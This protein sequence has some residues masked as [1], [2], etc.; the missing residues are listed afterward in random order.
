[1]TAGI[2]TLLFTDIVGSTERL[3]RLGDDAYDRL[4]RT[5]FRLLRD[6]V[7]ARGGNEVKNLGDGLFVTFPSVVNAVTAAIEMQQAVARESPTEDEPFEIR[8]GLSIGEPIVDESDY[9]GKPVVVAQRL[10]AAAEPGQILASTLVRDLAATRQ[11]VEVREMGPQQLK[12]IAEPV[13]AVE[14]IWAPAA[15]PAL[16]PGL[17]PFDGELFVGREEELGMLLRTWNEAQAGERRAVLIGGEPGIGKSSLAASAARAAADHGAIVLYGRCDEDLGVPYQPFVEALTQYARA[18]SP[19]QL[20]RQAG[21]NIGELVRLL[22]DLAGWYDDLP[23]PVRGEPETERYQLFR[24]VADLF[25]GIA[26]DRPV[27]LV[28]DDIHWAAKP[29]LLLLWHLLRNSAAVPLM[30]IATYRHTEVDRDHILNE[31]LADLHRE[32]GVERTVLGGLDRA[33]VGAFVAAVRGPAAAEERATLAEAI[34]A[35]TDGNP[36]FVR[37][38][39]AHLAENNLGALPGRGAPE[40]VLPD[41]VR[42]VVARR[43]ARLSTAANQVL[44]VGS[45][46]GPVFSIEL[47]EHLSGTIDDTG[48]VLEA[49]EE[50]VGAGLLLEDHAFVGR[51]VFAHAL[52]RET[53]YDQLGAVRRA[54]LHRRVGEV[55][56]TLPD[57]EH[58]LDELAYH[59]ARAVP[60]GQAEKA[61]GYGVRAGRRALEGLAYE[62]GVEHLERALAALEAGASVDMRR[63]ADLLLL[64]ADARWLSGDRPGAVEAV[65]RAAEDA[66]ATGSAQALAQAFCIRAEWGAL[67][68]TP[69]PSTV[70]LGEE[71]LEAL[72]D[73]TS[74]LK[75]R[76][77]AGLADY[78]ALTTGS[79]ALARDL[80]S[81]ALELARAGDDVDTLDYVLLIRAATFLGTNQV[82][83]QLELLDEALKL[84]QATGNMRRRHLGLA[85]R[86]TALLQAGEMARFKSD[87]Q[88][89]ACLGEERR[90]WT[91][92]A[93]ASV[94]AVAGA[95]AEGRFADV[96]DL[97]AR[98]LANTERDPNF[99]NT[100]AVQML[101]LRWEQGRLDELIP[102]LIGMAAQN[103]DLVAF[104]TAL[105]FA[106][107]EVGALG[108]AR[109]LLDSLAGDGFAA[110]PQDLTWP[111]SLALLASAAA[112]LDT[113]HH[114][115]K[116]FEF[117][118]PLSG[119]LVIVGAGAL[120]LGSVDRYLGMLAACGKDFDVA[121]GHYRSALE[122]EFR[123]GALPYVARTRYWY[124]RM[125]V[126]RGGS[127]DREE[128]VE[129]L[130]ACLRTAKELGMAT[131]QQQALAALPA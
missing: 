102:M 60:D 124:A 84:Q 129:L 21:S 70:Q 109:Q 40:S 9:F 54:R 41:S 27:L 50:A 116:L 75:A 111:T 88:E 91:A 81:R 22:P 14:I 105:A 24:A 62:E 115:R 98:V 18:S 117:L 110:V 83:T 39:L 48:N 128:S 3:D 37:E 25:A 73:E 80:A 95:L 86:A 108:E 130:D 55:L 87:A 85:L 28:L 58:R 79:G 67:I 20:R 45:V 69:D 8:V 4:R 63:R 42:D 74:P 32:A 92:A 112:D 106:H 36:F 94:L 107:A 51:Y 35:E 93:Y 44:R 66:R 119:Q 30:V 118:R 100:Y 82:S 47:L 131:L 90:S 56:E 23:P 12:G 114:A 19:G 31:T 72:A 7:A 53:L 96:E 113:Q 33:A 76:V 126:E 49:L 78:H 103:P 43:V 34:H 61:V 16:P 77:L 71:A 59:F 121:E 120:C 11:P 13:P 57:P 99:V 29:T 52:V 65:Q 122:L 38:V 10:C 68:G 104:R 17:Q 46:A 123:I 101:V 15:P 97:S 64:L 89:L 5:H 125:L 6:V 2:V 127:G 1:M 26:E